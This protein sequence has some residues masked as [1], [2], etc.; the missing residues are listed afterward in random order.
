[1]GVVDPLAVDDLD[2]HALVIDGVSA[3]DDDDLGWCRRAPCVVI[4]CT[5]EGDRPVRSTDLVL[6]DDEVDA[7]LEP[8]LAR[9]GANPQ[10]CRVL[11]DVLR[12]APS[13]DVPTGLTL[14]SLAYSTLLAGGEFADWL[15]DR[16]ASRPRTFGSPPV[17]VER[18][19]RELRVTLARPENRNAFSA[20]MRDALYEALTLA[21]IDS[22]IDRIVVAA[23][24]PVFSSGGDLAEFGTRPDIVQ[25]HTIRT[26]RSAGALLARLAPRVT[27]QVH[28]ACVGAGV[29]LSAFAGRVVADPDAT[30]RLPEIAMGLIP[31]AGGTVAITR[32]LGRQRTARFAMLGEA[33]DAEEALAIGLVDDVP[34]DGP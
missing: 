2:G 33:I 30:F 13:L 4:G 21:E 19:D 20:A 18:T 5:G 32:R 10:A 9:I 16:P 27:A 24:G 26:Q 17:R 7:L 11:V 31:G 12:A 1:M 23:D 14:E 25:A 15:A 8:L 22:T 34:E 29:E 28:G 3:A 6:V